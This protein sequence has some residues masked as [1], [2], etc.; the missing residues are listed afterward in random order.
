MSDYV[1]KEVIHW[2]IAFVIALTC[3]LLVYFLKLDYKNA[4]A[5]FV[6]PF[7]L[8]AAFLYGVSGLIFVSRCGMFDTINYGFKAVGYS[9]MKDPTERKYRDLTDYVE[10][11]NAI[12]KNS[13]FIYEA[14]LGVGTIC[15]VLAIIFYFVS[16]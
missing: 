13:R 8:G 11:K 1:K 4:L 5:R 16:R 12:R 9:F 10:Q 15:L 14:Y 6:D 7:F 2:S 3:F